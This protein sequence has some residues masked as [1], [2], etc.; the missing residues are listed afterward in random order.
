MA[1]VTPRSSTVRTIIIISTE[2][3]STRDCADIMLNELFT[4][5]TPITL[6]PVV[7]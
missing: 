2:G 5:G 6:G 3:S 4:F 7:L 1:E